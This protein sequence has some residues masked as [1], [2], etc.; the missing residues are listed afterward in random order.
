MLEITL[1]ALFEVTT[2]SHLLS[3]DELQCVED[4]VAIKSSFFFLNEFDT[5]LD[6]TNKVGCV[7]KA[8]RYVNDHSKLHCMTAHQAIFVNL[9]LWHAPLTFFGVNMSIL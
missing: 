3:Q 5:E 9:Q 1:L 6:F 7:Y 8:N 2:H 4:K